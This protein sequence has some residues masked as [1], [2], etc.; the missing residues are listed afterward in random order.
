LWQTVDEHEAAIGRLDGAIQ[1]ER[2]QRNRIM[3]YLVGIGVTSF[4]GLL[5][6]L[7]RFI[8]EQVM[9]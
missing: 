8:F 6:F 1:H 9:R 7:G 3:W 4:I 2:T 5:A